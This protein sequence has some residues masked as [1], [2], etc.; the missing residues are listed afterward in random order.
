M[1]LIVLVA[2]GGGVGSAARYLVALTLANRFGALFP[3]G[4]LTVNILGS[5][6]IGLLATLADELG[7]IGPHLRL[8]LVV[9][10]LGGFTTFSSFSLETLRLAEENELARAGLNVAGN[11]VCSL[12]AAM[13]GMALARALE[14]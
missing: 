7:S 14:R 3:W 1:R 4:T 6:L 9:G 11:L 10:V 5:F 2:V 13:I 8:F 12:A